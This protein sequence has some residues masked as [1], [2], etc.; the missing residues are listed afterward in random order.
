[1]IAYI[2]ARGGSK[3][4]P[5]KN[6]RL[7][8]GKPVIVHVIDTLRSLSFIEKVCV[9]TDDEEIASIVRNAGAETLELRS[10]ALSNDTASFLDLIR[11]DVPRF[12]KLARDQDQFLFVLAT[13]AL[14]P[15][16]TYEQALAVFSESKADAALSVHEMDPNPSLAM[17][18]DASGIINAVFPAQLA[19][20]TQDMPKYFM[21]AGCFYMIRHSAL[22]KHNRFF[23]AVCAGVEVPSG[24]AIDVDQESDWRRLEEKFLS[25]EAKQ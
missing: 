15:A 19:M 7:L 13:S 5:R 1:M 12:L 3:R 8:G 10:P 16:S 22:I 25:R 4:I 21:D 2:P 9:S 14:I 6:V 18:R 20:R 17:T 24:I 11:E 23:D